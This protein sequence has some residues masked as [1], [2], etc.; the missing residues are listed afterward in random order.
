MFH[1]PFWSG[2]RTEKRLI[3]EAGFFLASCLRRW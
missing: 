1:T 2:Y 3:L